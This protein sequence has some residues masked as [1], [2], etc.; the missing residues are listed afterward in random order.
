MIKMM[1][2]HCENVYSKQMCFI[3]IMHFFNSLNLMRLI[4]QAEKDKDDFEKK[5]ITSE[6]WAK[7]CFNSHS[8]LQV[9][10]LF[11]VFKKKQP[12]KSTNEQNKQ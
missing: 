10:T 8:I 5:K 2:D 12:D 11:T 6:I 1:P 3:K 7:E 9:V 4:D